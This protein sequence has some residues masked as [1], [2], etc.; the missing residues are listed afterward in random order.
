MGAVEPAPKVER[1]IAT[2]SYEYIN[3]PKK[4]EERYVNPLG[5]TVVS[6]RTDLETGL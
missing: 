5:F 1:Y 4:E 3:A 2:I 6:Y